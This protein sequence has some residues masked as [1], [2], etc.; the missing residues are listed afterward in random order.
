MAR[1]HTVWL[2][3]S[4]AAALPMKVFTVKHEMRTWLIRGGYAPQNLNI[5]AYPD[6]VV[7]GRQVVH[8]DAAKLLS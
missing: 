1:A 2:V 4:G 7:E 5:Y 6:G 8:L 3:F